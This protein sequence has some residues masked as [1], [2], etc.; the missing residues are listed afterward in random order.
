[1]TDL[2]HVSAVDFYSAEGFLL[3]TADVTVGDDGTGQLE[4]LDAEWW[5]RAS[6]AVFT[7]AVGRPLESF[8]LQRV[9][10]ND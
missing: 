8:E 3:G 1:M 7:D 4:G 10:H 2:S 6:R 9:H 5:S